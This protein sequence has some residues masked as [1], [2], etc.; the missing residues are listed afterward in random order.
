M[1]S[2]KKEKLRNQVVGEM[3][4]FEQIPLMLE[5]KTNNK[6]HFIIKTGYQGL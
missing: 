4:K 5:K 6:T 3:N 2:L 1:L